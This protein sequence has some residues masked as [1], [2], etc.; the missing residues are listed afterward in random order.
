M[1][2]DINVRVAA[3]NDDGYVDNS[4]L[5]NTISNIFH[6]RYYAG[7]ATGAFYRFL[8]VTIPAGS[9]ISNAYITYTPDSSQSTN[10]VSIR[11]YGEQSTNA[12]QITSVA[13]YNNRIVTTAYVDW[14]PVSAWVSGVAINSPDLSTIIQ[15]LVDDYG[16][17]SSANIQI[18]C[19]NNGGDANRNR[20]C[21]SYNGD[22]SKAPLLHITYVA[23]G[24]WANIAKVRG[25]TATDLAKVNGIVVANVA[26]LNGVA[27]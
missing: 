17:L 14:N 11:Y 23:T 26:K 2:T 12:S 24:G 10:T 1:A 20:T 15:E 5:W 18:L 13:D 8:G 16:G 25:A 9:T 21:W 3:G 4:T 19:K 6:G 7:T 22:S 27:V